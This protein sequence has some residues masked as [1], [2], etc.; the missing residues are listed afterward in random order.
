MSKKK[1]LV[2]FSDLEPVDD[3]DKEEL[4]LH[5]L[6]HEGKMVF[7]TDEATKNKHSKIFK[8]SNHKRANDF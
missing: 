8:E 6:L 4:S 5:H 7:H 3:L 1:T 2:D